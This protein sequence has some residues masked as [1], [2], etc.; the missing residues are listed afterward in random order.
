MCKR[1]VYRA[2]ARGRD[3][4]LVFPDKKGHVQEKIS[5]S[6]YR[7][8]NELK[9]NEGVSDPRDKVVYHT[10]RHSYA[11]NLVQAGVDLYPVQRLMG[12]SN[13]KIYIRGTL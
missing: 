13:S 12:H 7:V 6:F 11:S 4:D 1:R 10:F 5:H 3:Q 2:P 9:L 8:V